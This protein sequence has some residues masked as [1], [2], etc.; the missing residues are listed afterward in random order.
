[1]FSIRYV[2]F[3]SMLTYPRIVISSSRASISIFF[4]AGDCLI[5]SELPTRGSFFLPILFA[6]DADK[7]TTR[8]IKTP[9]VM[10]YDKS[11]SAM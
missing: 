7:I 4:Q 8:P 6:L 1:M 5:S 9:M 10:A 3:F 2:V 11:E